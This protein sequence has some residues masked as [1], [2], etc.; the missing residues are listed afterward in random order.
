MNPRIALIHALPQAIGPVAQSFRELWP[1]AETVNIM[2]DRLS[3]DRERAGELTP[4]ISERI[5]QLARYA[6]RCNA[7]AIL[8][9]C[10]AFGPAIEAV[11]RWSSIPVLKPSEAMFGEA[12]ER[13]GRIAMLL[14]FQP[15]VASME[16]EFRLQAGAGGAALSTLCVPEAMSALQRGDLAAH[17]KLLA[18]AA[19]GIEADV[20]MLGQF[21]M[22]PA[23][24]A[25]QSAV[26]CTVL[27]SPDSAV[28]RLKGV[29]AGT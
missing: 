29:L 18:E 5:S 19:R 23:R 11:G 4:E 13:G 25:V 8:Y 22:A 6:M 7:N 10:S 2:D 12:L 14:T 17:N 21:S 27:T 24:E 3:V 28:R 26:R 16:E 15:S 9:T 1:D 20:L